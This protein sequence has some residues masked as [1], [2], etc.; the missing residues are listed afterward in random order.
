MAA[1]GIRDRPSRSTSSAT[2]TQ[3]TGSS[4]T[5]IFTVALPD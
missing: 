3:S 2:W 4:N 1:I 5:D